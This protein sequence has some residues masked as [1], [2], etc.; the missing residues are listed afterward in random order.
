VQ[1][2]TGVDALSLQALLHLHSDSRPISIAS[3]RA[4]KNSLAVVVR[5]RFA[6]TVTILILLT[7]FA[8]AQPPAAVAPIPA[9]GGQDAALRT[10]VRALIVV[11][12]PDDETC[13]AATVYE[14]THN[15]G[16]TVDQLLVTNGE[17]GYRYSLLADSF[18]GVELTDEA[19]GRAAL[20]EI[21]KRES[22]DAGHI[23]GIA[24]HF[25]LDQPD[26]RYTQDI[27]EVL[28]QHWNTSVVLGDVQRRIAAGNYDFVFTLFPSPETHGAHKAA[29]I[30]ALN[31]VEQVMGR[32]PGRRPVVLGCQDSRSG[33]QAQ[34]SWQGFQSARHPFRALPQVF[35]TDRT[36]KFGFRNA[37]DY[38]IIVNWVIAA[39]KSQGALQMDVNRADR[40]E[41]VILESGAADEV[42][43]ASALFQKLAE[44]AAHPKEVG[45]SVP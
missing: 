2:Q 16:G 25:F 10:P 33:D 43:R 26:L 5:T 21:R 27:D 1:A 4:M 42:G 7:G 40:E 24:N 11:A 22:L 41:F 23:L 8:V 20:P 17:G 3:E 13:L 39:H 14:I 30:T 12:H 32:N 9:G 45:V 29:A 6:R 38:Q 28:N 35:V 36:V 19:I 37:L 31:A 34:P 15:L 44:Q 18:Y